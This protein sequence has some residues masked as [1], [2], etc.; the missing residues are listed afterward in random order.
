[1]FEILESSTYEWTDMFMSGMLLLIGTG[2]VVMALLVVAY[3]VDTCGIIGLEAAGTVVG[4]AYRG[5]SIAHMPMIVG[6]TNILMPMDDPE[7]FWLW[8]KMED[9]H[10]ASVRVSKSCY[11]RYSKGDS[12]SFVYSRGRISGSVYIWNVYGTR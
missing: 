12:V 1:M 8:I 5:E 7:S 11:H 9:G 10:E 2:L 6:S 4:R 3:V